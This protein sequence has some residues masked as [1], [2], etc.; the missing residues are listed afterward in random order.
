MGILKRRVTC[1]QMLCSVM[2]MML[3][4]A[5]VMI[6]NATTFAAAEEGKGWKIDDTGVLTV[7]G[8]GSQGVLAKVD[9]KDAKAWEAHKDEVTAIKVEGN[10]TAI[11]DEVFKG[12]SKVTTV[13]FADTVTEIGVS[14]FAEC[15]ALTSVKLPAGV[16][17]IRQKAFQKCTEITEIT[18]PKTVVTIDGETTG[19]FDG[20]TK[21][22]T[23]T[24]EDGLA[25]I[26]DR[27][28]KGCY[29]ITKINWPAGL[30]TIGSYAFCN[31]K[32]YTVGT[33]P[34]TVTAVKSNAFE[35][36]KDTT[37]TVP[38]N[39][40]TFGHPF[41]NIT[42]ISF[43]AGTTKIPDS[44]CESVTTLKKINWPE[45]V[46]EI[47]DYA[48]TITLLDEIIIP[49]TVTKVGKEAFSK[50][51][52]VASK[53]FIPDSLKSYGDNA[54]AEMAIN[55]LRY[56]DVVVTGSSNSKAKEIVDKFKS[57]KYSYTYKE[58]VVPVKG[59]TYT[60]GD[61]QYK[62]T[63][64]AL[65]GKGTVAVSGFAKKTLKSVTI[66][67]T[68]K[69]GDYSFKVTGINA[70]AFKGMSKL[71]K[72]TVK[73]TDIT[74]VQKKAFKGLSAKAKIKVP[75]AKLSAYKKLFKKAGLSKKVKVSK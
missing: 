53:V 27:M 66:P 45:G 25:A 74:K 41:G 48:F 17:K 9:A 56:K 70:N 10:V 38:K 60:V 22:A 75:K 2:S 21:L 7:T 34:A 63:D 68:V 58:I 3:A 12:Y 46:T 20:C 19:P 32:E 33:L 57:G 44:C 4:L 37:F 30:T 73:T 62:M 24:F 65:D 47:G 55:P 72:I 52:A 36:C 69:V 42:E 18:I 59:K 11:G 43:E 54:F 71:K 1:R 29:W 16:Q 15:S 26:P 35:M 8:G 51:Q 64:A 13:E 23:V 5:L 6:F 14:A 61:V 67:K 40:T 28:F 50:N 49:D 31:A 39:M